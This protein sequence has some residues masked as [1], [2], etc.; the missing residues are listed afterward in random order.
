MCCLDR[1]NSNMFGTFFKHAV[2]SPAEAE[3]FASFNSYSDEPPKL[4]EVFWEGHTLRVPEAF[5]QPVKE[6]LEICCC[7]GGGLAQRDVE[8]AGWVLCGVSGP[9]VNQVVVDLSMLPPD[10]L[11]V[12]SG[13]VKDHLS[14]DVLEVLAEKSVEHEVE[15]MNHSRECHFS[16]EEMDKIEKILGFMCDRRNMLPTLNKLGGRLRRKYR[17]KNGSEMP[18]GC[19]QFGRDVPVLSAHNCEKCGSIGRIYQMI[20]GTEASF[21]RVQQVNQNADFHSLLE[22]ELPDVESLLRETVLEYLKELGIDVNAPMFAGFVAHGVANLIAILDLFQEAPG[23]GNVDHGIHSHLIQI[24]ALVEN[25][26]L[27]HELFVKIVERGG[28]KHI[29]DLFSN[30]SIERV[31]V[32]LKSSHLT[33]LNY[34]T[35]ATAFPQSMTKSMMT[36]ADTRAIKTIL[37]GGDKVRTRKL[38]KV[39]FGKA[40]NIDAVGDED[41]RS[42]LENAADNLRAFE[43]ASVDSAYKAMDAISKKG[44]ETMD[45][46]FSGERRF[47]ESWKTTPVA[48]HYAEKKWKVYQLAEGRYLKEVDVLAPDS[49]G[50]D[51]RGVYVLYPPGTQLPQELGYLLTK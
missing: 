11:L 2:D 16:Q 6:H 47:D 21:L 28:W 15:M 29:L 35:M 10:E 13:K 51:E 40:V 31:S 43:V 50:P 34:I 8:N 14:D 38:A 45:S 22:K 49:S 12:P 1:G 46:Y 25:Q 36:G 48:R 37:D 19:V 7:L 33:Y 44:G 32:D 39:V 20:Y 17:Q 41:V 23:A 30:S 9:K 18:H 27:D 4:V 24:A 5:A 26:L 42:M 3:G